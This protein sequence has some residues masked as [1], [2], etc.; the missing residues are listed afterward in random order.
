MKPIAVKNKKTGNITSYQFRVYVGEDSFGKKRLVTKTWK[1]DKNYTPKQ[2]E[3]ELQ[4]QQLIFEE[5][6][7]E[8]MQD[9]SEVSGIQKKSSFKQFA[10]YWIENYSK[11]NH[12]LSTTA[13]YETSLKRV[14]EYIGNL[15]LEKITPMTINAMYNKLRKTGKCN[16]T[17][18]T[19][20]SEKSIKN[21]HAMLCSMFASAVDWNII[22]LGSN[23][24][25]G[26]KSPKATRK[27][28]KPFTAQ[29]V[30]IIF[31]KLNEEPLKYNLMIKLDI[32][33]GMRRGE[34]V[35]LKWENVN[36][37][38]DT[39]EINSSR[40]YTSSIGVYEDTTKTDESQRIV[41]VS[42]EIMSLLSLYH[43]QQENERAI[44]GENWQD[45]GYV[46][47]SEFGKPIHPNSIYNWFNR[48]LE[49]CG[50]EKRSIH[51]MRHTTATLLIMNG[52]NVKLVSG[53][54]GHNNTQ[55]TNNIYASYIKEA[56]E[57]VSDTL[58]DI[59][60]KKDQ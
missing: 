44:C 56:D 17:K 33:A 16:R 8:S 28:P 57:L 20:L 55:T 41:K 30:A 39:I 50:I 13:S 1:P 12:K 37:A 34:L 10:N 4:R 42:D 48:F 29:E 49:R 18:D 54:L 60:F 22:R 2:L 32:E 26:V 21:Y 59:L 53:R 51:S 23:P 11:T 36:F 9:G 40:L 35:G 7:L 5:S 31:E 58:S 15:P 46:F 19:G 43:E 52:V 24:M 45:S 47:V 14:N 6:A 27:K 25:L 3:K 38:Q